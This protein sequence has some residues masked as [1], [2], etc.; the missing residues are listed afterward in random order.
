VATIQEAMTQGADLL[1][2]A[3]AGTIDAASFE[4]QLTSLL[5]APVAARGLMAALST[6][7]IPDKAEVRKVLIETIRKNQET[8]YELILK[9]IVMPLCA[10]QEHDRQ[11]R[12]EQAA[13]SR[14]TCSNT[15]ELAK[16]LDD[17]RLA[18]MA[19]NLLAA[20]EHFPEQARP[21][22]DSSAHERDELDKWYEF[23]ERWHYSRES[24]LAAKDPLTKIAGGALRQ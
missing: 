10:A 16:L 12:P 4:R 9:N 5:E 18:K 13:L 6:G 23:F 15:Q 8:T 14:R 21:A 3:A 2:Q 11:N 24:L 7:T 20:I 22:T 1:E 17:P 19:D